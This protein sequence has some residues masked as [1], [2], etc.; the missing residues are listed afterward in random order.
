MRHT[1][2]S[3]RVQICTVQRSDAQHTIAIRVDQALLE[4]VEN[5]PKA[6]VETF[7]EFVETTSRAYGRDA[8]FIDALKREYNN[9]ILFF[10]ERK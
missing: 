3:F 7:C 8:H 6:N 4:T 5:T 1:Y 2:G 9:H 10:Y